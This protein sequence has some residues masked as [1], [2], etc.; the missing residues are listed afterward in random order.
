MQ[1]TSLIRLSAFLLAAAIALGAFGAHALENVLTSDRLNTWET[2]V[3]YHTW[4]AL[5]VMLIAVIQH[6]LKTEITFTAY[7]I[8]SGMIIFS[9]SLYILCL[10]D[11]GIFGAITPIG[12]VLLIVGWIL[13]GVKVVGN[14]QSLTN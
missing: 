1:S 10:T 2:A 13:F 8:L 9:G 12:G 6:Q 14:K 7:L 5:G 3:F 4:N 11:I